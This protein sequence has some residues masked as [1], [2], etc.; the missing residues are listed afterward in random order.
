MGRTKE[1]E[2]LPPMNSHSG[3]APMSKMDQG[4]SLP[5]D[6]GA[7]KGAKGRCYHI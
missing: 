1:T 5:E 6:K 3:G 7:S 4:D 2:A